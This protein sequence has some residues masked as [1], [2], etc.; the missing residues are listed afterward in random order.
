MGNS[1]VHPGAL[2][3][4]VNVLIARLSTFSDLIDLTGPI[5]GDLQSCLNMI[6][7]ILRRASKERST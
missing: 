1:F 5:V 3:E 4:A 7:E 6:T 2:F